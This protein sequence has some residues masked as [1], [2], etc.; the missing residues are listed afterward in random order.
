MLHPSLS[1]LKNHRDS[2]LVHLNI[3]NVAPLDTTY[4]EIFKLIGT[5]DKILKLLNTR[6]N[7]RGESYAVIEQDII[8]QTKA[9][10]DLLRHSE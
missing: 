10:M 9:L 4:A 3:Q 5:A 8:L 7:M 1:N 2:F 6:L